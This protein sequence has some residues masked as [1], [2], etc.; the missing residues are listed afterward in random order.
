MDPFKRSIFMGQNREGDVFSKIEWDGRRLT[1]DRR[2][3]LPP[4]L[5]QI[6]KRWHLNDMRP[7]CSHQRLWQTDKVL[8]ITGL[9]W[10]TA[11]FAE[12]RRAANGE[13]SV[14]DYSVFSQRAKIV[15][16]VTTPWERPKHPDLWP[17]SVFELM[18]LSFLKEGKREQ[19]T[20]GWVLPEEHPEGLLTKA[21]G[22]CGYRYGSAWL[23]EE[24]PE[25]VLQQLYDLP[26]K[27]SSL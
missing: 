22:E 19:K 13:M 27:P 12:G 16:S 26:I 24:V 20:A 9:E 5:A 25:D 11:F 1:F 10:G 14:S 21:C 2:G 15:I 3:V 8:T 6:A 4:S 18:N 7:G 17:S 23:Y